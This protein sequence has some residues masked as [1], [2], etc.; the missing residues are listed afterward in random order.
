MKKNHKR[1]YIKYIIRRY[2][3]IKSLY[4]LSVALH[5]IL[6]YRSIKTTDDLYK[7]AQKLCLLLFNLFLGVFN[8]SVINGLRFYGKP[9]WECTA[10][11]IE[12]HLNLWKILNVKSISKG[13]S[14]M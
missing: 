1:N 14:T 12:Y 3:C 8:E 9:A 7:F 4:F 6:R 11:F 10:N 5:F 13:K 2:A